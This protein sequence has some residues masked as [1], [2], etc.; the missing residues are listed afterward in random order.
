MWF[1]ASLR[2]AADCVYHSLVPGH[3]RGTRRRL[4]D[5]DDRRN[6]TCN[7]IAAGCRVTQW[8]HR[9]EQEFPLTA[10][11]VTRQKNIDNLY[12]LSCFTCW[13]GF[14]GCM[15]SSARAFAEKLYFSFYAEHRLSAQSTFTGI[16]GYH[17]KYLKIEVQSTRIL[18]TTI[19]VLVDN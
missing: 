2:Y 4:E 16:F 10:T 5:S 3:G 15:V 17:T 1:W 11:V 9:V 18:K 14:V 7:L 12:S 19:H 8:C 6:S 13:C